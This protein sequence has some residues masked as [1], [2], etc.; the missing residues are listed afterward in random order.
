MSVLA[1]NE[2]KKSL[3]T[4]SLRI[5]VVEDN[6]LNTRIAQTMLTSMDHSIDTARNGYEAYHAVMDGQ[7]DL[8]FMDI[9]MPLLDGISSTRKIRKWEKQH[10]LK[11]HII[12]AMSANK[13]EDY[14]FDCIEAGMND[15]LHKPFIKSELETII[16]KN[17]FS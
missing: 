12:I 2:I 5:L 6:L 10:S 14:L 7:Y 3:Q 1:I 15:Y 8:I 13:K 11:P 17:M 16:I 4:D 9:E